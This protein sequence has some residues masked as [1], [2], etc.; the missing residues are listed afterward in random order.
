MHVDLRLLRQAQALMEHG[1]FSRAANALAQSQPTLSR[2]IKDLEERVGLPLFTRERTGV[3]PTDFGL[4]FMQHATDLLARAGDLERE[5]ALVKGLRSG[6]VALGTGVYPADTMA[7]KCATRFTAAHPYVR[8]RVTVATPAELARLLRART[9]DLVVAEASA[10]AKVDDLEVLESLE[11]LPAFIVTRAGHPLATRK[12]VEL[13][14]VLDYPYAQVQSLAPRVLQPMLASRRRP[15]TSR[16]EPIL[17]FPSLECPTA[18]FALDVVAATDA[19]TFASLGMIRGELER[20][21]LVP[22]LQ[23]PWLRAEWAIAR[24]RKRTLSPS[25]AALVEILGDAHR[26]N[27]VE[28]ARL[29]K[30]WFG[31][32][33]P[34]SR[35]TRRR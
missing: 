12:A 14:D 30:H 35:A 31:T 4:V 19:F 29:R 32:K 17:P 22:V 23:P 1:S 27:L 10:L 26:A 18:R 21:T 15:A 8:L 33:L 2:G 25:M 28:E 3:R 6:E 13:A 9:L 16:A 5:V 20:R 7:A 11:P 34:A 24:L